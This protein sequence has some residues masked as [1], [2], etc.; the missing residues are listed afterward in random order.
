MRFA[1]ALAALLLAGPARAA[2]FLT[3]SDLR[4]YCM[5][6]N[7]TSQQTAPST[8]LGLILRASQKAKN[9]PRNSFFWE[10]ATP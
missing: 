9:G 2:D 7:A 4:S 8:P 1:I 3:T 6:Q 5:S 10:G